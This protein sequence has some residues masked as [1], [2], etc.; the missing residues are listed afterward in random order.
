MLHS[1]HPGLLPEEQPQRSP[2]G[3]H[4]RGV[5]CG[6]Q[7]KASAPSAVGISTNLLFKC[8]RGVAGLQHRTGGAPLQRENLMS[9]ARPRTQL[10]IVSVEGCSWLGH[11]PVQDGKRAVG[12]LQWGPGQVAQRGWAVRV[13]G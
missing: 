4:R 2:E 13:C 11:R 3:R 5:T 8:G 10:E 1:Q 6:G 12:E 9:G 7:G